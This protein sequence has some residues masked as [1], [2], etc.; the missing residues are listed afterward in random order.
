[1]TAADQNNYTAVVNRIAALQ[2]QERY[3]GAFIFGSYV[4]DISHRG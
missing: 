1:M 2:Q 3:E 4:T